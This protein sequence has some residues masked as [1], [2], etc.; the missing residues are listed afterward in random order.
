M[1][2]IATQ[3]QTHLIHYRTQI[4]EIFVP[5]FFADYDSLSYVKINNTN[6][7][8]YRR[9]D[10]EIIYI[11]QKNITDTGKDVKTEPH[12]LSFYSFGNN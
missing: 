11:S 5:H 2:K 8:L 9:R 6:S 3:R 1:R 12:T 7:L 4:L 10:D